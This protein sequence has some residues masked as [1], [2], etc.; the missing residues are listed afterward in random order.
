LK[1]AVVDDTLRL[2]KGIERLLSELRSQPPDAWKP[3]NLDAFEGELF[4]A[5][6]G[7]GAHRL[8]ESIRS[9]ADSA[10]SLQALDRLEEDVDR[11]LRESIGDKRTE[12]EGQRF[13]HLLRNAADAVLIIDGR[14]GRILDSNDTSRRA[15]SYSREEHQRR[16]SRAEFSGGGG[17]PSTGV[18]GSMA[19]VG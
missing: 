12:I 18:G 7:L 3:D 10:T 8:E 1:E 15:L 16:A 4:R 14:T 6:S 5:T 2:L 9:A 11:I 13:L 19:R 17:I